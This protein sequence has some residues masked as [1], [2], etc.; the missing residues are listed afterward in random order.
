MGGP[1]VRCCAKC[2]DRY[3]GCHSECDRYKSE[4]ELVHIKKELIKAE[5]TKFYMRVTAKRRRE[6]KKEV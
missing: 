3:I 5:R 2:P 1:Y 4:A 6:K